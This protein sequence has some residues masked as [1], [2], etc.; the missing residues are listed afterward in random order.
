MKR[1]RTKWNAARC[2]R[3][4]V[5]ALLPTV[6]RVIKVIFLH[7]LCA[8]ISFFFFFCL[9]VIDRVRE[10]FN[11][12]RMVFEFKN[13]RIRFNISSEAMDPS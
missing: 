9:T 13:T 8:Q 4:G 12:R 1:G 3:L 7:A 10:F 6:P 11:R 2:H 5:G